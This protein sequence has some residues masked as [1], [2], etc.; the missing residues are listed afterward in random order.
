MAYATVDESALYVLSGCSVIETCK[1]QTQFSVLNLTMQT[2]D[3]TGPPWQ[4]LNTSITTQSGYYAWMTVSKDKQRLIV[5]DP[6][7]SDISIFSLAAKSWLPRQDVP[8]DS[9]GL[10]G[11]RSAL[12]PSTGLLYVPSGTSNG[13]M[14]VVYNTDTNVFSFLSMPSASGSIFVNFSYYSLVWSMYRNSM[15]L[16]GGYQ[17]YT[18]I[19]NPNL[20]EYKPT[21]DQW[22]YVSTTGYNPGD[23]YS[24]CMVPAYNGSKMVLFGGQDGSN[25]T[26]SSIFILDLKTLVWTKGV[27]ADASQKRHSMACT[28][29][30][31]NFIVWGGYSDSNTDKPG[32]PMII[33]NLRTDLWT[34]H[35]SP[36]PPVET[37]P[38]PTSGPTVDGNNAAAIGGGVAAGVVILG[39]GFL[40][41]RRNYSKRANKDSQTPLS[42]QQFPDNVP[43]MAAYDPHHTTSYQPQAAISTSQSDVY[44]RQSSVYAPVV[45]P[46]SPPPPPPLATFSPTHS[47]IVSG[48]QASSLSPPTTP[49]F[50]QDQQR[51]SLY[52][53]PVPPKD[54]NP[55]CAGPPITAMSLPHQSMAA[56]D[57]QIYTTEHH[58]E[59]QALW[60]QSV[61][62]PGESVTVGHK[63]HD[64]IP[65]ERRVY[66]PTPA[67]HGPILYV[68][69]SAATQDSASSIQGG[70][71]GNPQTSLDSRVSLADSRALSHGSGADVNNPLPTIPLTRN[72]QENAQDFSP[73]GQEMHHTIRH[74]KSPQDYSVFVEEERRRQ[75]QKEQY[76][77]PVHQNQQ[78]GAHHGTKS[79][80]ELELERQLAAIKEQNTQQQLDVE[81]LQF[82]MKN[83]KQRM[84][85]EVGEV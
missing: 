57:P 78:G 42:M 6:V 2:W 16:Y 19:R 13:T 46:Y 51:Q 20:V 80:R 81:L 60:Q 72:P 83:L 38:S 79:A 26:L 49:P 50:V 29:A 21:L 45:A 14:M 9:R 85:S 56:R 44:P 74:I 43:A 22:T 36:I 18:Q 35:F 84:N 41:Y 31:D 7:G 59:N 15:L 28:A 32:K 63:A 23:V 4:S 62:H 55:G 27:D 34:N 40:F 65:P 58:E 53:P 8:V 68:L 61:Q 47:T 77:Q 33:Y 48:T 24:H 37:S 17:Y 82:E 71:R 73:Q 64:P 52:I 5:W 30:G 76:Q 1:T 66:E 70:Q 10:G 75:Q 12:D 25:L 69:G 39:V 67:P 3:N 54:A 11:T